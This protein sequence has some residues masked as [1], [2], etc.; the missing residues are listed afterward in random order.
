MRGAAGCSPEHLER[1]RELM[2]PSV[3][4]HQ[5]RDA[6]AQPSPTWLRAEIAEALRDLVECVSGEAPLLIQ[7]DDVQ[8]LGKSIEWLWTDLLSWS[9]ERSVAW[10]F[11]ARTTR[12]QE[13][14][15]NA[16]SVVVGALDA[17]A[18]SELLDD[19]LRSST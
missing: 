13:F 10:L 16:P 5:R 8:W 18:A 12:R 15:L 11:A 1:L 3:D 9:A 2:N 6:E 7:V 19:L 17:T 4:A 14:K